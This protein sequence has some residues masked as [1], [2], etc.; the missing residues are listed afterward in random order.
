MLHVLYMVL[1]R[2]SLAGVSTSRSERFDYDW[3][4]LARS[5]R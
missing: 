4:A 5:Y 3:S 2:G 1:I